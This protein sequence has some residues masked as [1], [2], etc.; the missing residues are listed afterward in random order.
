VDR[1]LL[2]LMAQWI[3]AEMARHNAEDERDRH[4]VQLA[5]V[6][7]LTTMGEMASGLAHEINQPLTAAANFTSGSLRRLR[8]PEPDIGNVVAGMEKALQGVNRATDIIRHLREFVQTGVPDQ[9]RFDINASVRRVLELVAPEARRAEV[10]L[11]SS[12]LCAGELWLQGDS[13]QLEQVIMNLVRNAVEASPHGGRVVIGSSHEDGQARLWVRDQGAG[14][15]SAAREHLFDP[16]FTTK[17]DGMGLGLAISRSIV[18]AHGGRLWAEANSPGAC[19]IF[20][21]PLSEEG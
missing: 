2:R 8:E 20:Q 21:L 1:E 16:F 9:Q 19:F 14:L 18:E 10:V 17:R 7:R 6:G 4:R 15:D 3:G 13:I 12:V 11:D 5:Q